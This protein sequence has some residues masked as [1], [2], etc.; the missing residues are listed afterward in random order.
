MELSVDY[1]VANF[2]MQNEDGGIVS[3][4]GLMAVRAGF[5]WGSNENT[6]LWD[7]MRS[8]ART[9]NPTEVK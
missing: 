7:Q 3:Q 9:L 8:A 2:T 4:Y 6:I 5:N 1:S